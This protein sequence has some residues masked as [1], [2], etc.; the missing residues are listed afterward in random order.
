MT[1]T[2]SYHVVNFY[3]YIGQLQIRAS[4][5]AFIPGCQFQPGFNILLPFLYLVLRKQKIIYICFSS[6]WVFFSNGIFH[7]KMRFYI[8]NIHNKVKTQICYFKSIVI[9]DFYQMKAY[10]QKTNIKTHTKK[11]S[12]HLYL[13]IF[14]L[15]SSYI[16]QYL[17]NKR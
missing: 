13:L 15:K 2:T 9:E 12:L 6:I 11:Q 10:R 16:T 5:S 14:N 7:M 3:I 17:N 4:K 1:T 8:L